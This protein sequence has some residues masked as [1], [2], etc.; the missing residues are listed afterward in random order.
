MLPAVGEV[1]VG[2]EHELTTLLGLL[3]EAQARQPRIGTGG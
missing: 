3:G 2:R 1:L